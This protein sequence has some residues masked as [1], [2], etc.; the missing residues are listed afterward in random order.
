LSLG[1]ANIAA[2][3]AIIEHE[4]RARWL[5]RNAVHKDITRGGA[6]ARPERWPRSRSRADLDPAGRCSCFNATI[7]AVR[8]R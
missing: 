5:R 4:H 7:S 6:T 3:A 2:P 8:I 1:E